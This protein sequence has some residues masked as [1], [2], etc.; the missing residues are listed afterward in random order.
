VSR[1]SRR[2]H[3]PAI[4]VLTVVWLLLWDQVSVFILVTGVLLA[5]AV[6]LVF[7]LPPIELHGR[8]R[9]LALGRLVARLLADLF[10]SSVAVVALAFRFGT[11][12]RSAIVRVRLRTRSDLYLTQTAE[13]VSLVPGSI[14]LEV[15]RSTHTLYLHVLDSVEPAALD[16]AVKDVLDA[17]ARV[18]RAF[19]S[20]AE[21]AALESGGPMP[22]TE[23]ERP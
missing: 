16:Q 14:V 9:P 2:L 5:M 13:L 10:R 20:A 23:G 22:G 8:I 17:E 4:V 7:P 19:G 18:L 12:P 21:I 6:S 11:T 3:L 15:H 1:P